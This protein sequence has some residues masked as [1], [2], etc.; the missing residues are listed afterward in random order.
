MGADPIAMCGNCRKVTAY[1]DL[2]ACVDCINDRFATNINET[3]GRVVTQE[4]EEKGS[5][6]FKEP[7]CHRDEICRSLE[8]I[9]EET[10][11][12]HRVLIDPCW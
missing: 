8:K 10:K 9:V 12:G 2:T 7:H 1:F 5:K 11:K 4:H 6:L 3:K